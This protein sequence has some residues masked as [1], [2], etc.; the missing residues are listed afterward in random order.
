MELQREVPLELAF[1]LVDEAAVGVEARHLVF[2]LV[3]HQLE[4]AAGDRLGQALTTL[5]ATGLRRVDLGH[6][7]T[8][9]LRIGSVLVRGQIRRAP[10][11]ELGEQGG[12]R[13]FVGPHHRTRRRKTS[14]K[15]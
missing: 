11:D 8:V 5:G 6:E 15:T 2:V 1:E 3:G 9:L 7:V 10:R 13:R 12:R 14:G 4:K